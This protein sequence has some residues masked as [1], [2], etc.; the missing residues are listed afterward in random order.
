MG[1]QDLRDV[2]TIIF[3]S[4]SAEQGAY[5]SLQQTALQALKYAILQQEMSQQTKMSAVSQDANII[6]QV[7]LKE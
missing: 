6:M 1:Q 7:I 2:L 3:M 4:S 5:G